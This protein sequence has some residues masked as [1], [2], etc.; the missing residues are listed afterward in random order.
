MN[1]WEETT[2]GEISKSI[3]YGYTESAP[4]NSTDPKFL[5]ITDIQEDF[6]NWDAVPH[7]PI[8]K[9]DFLKYKLEIGDIC[10]ARTG[11]STGAVGGASH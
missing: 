1:Q 2:L 10:I 6:I 9:D 11:N 8:N 3:Q 7:C 5:R 4:D